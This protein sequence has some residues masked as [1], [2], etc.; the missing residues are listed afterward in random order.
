MSVDPDA[1]LAEPALDGLDDAATARTSRAPRRLGLALAEGAGRRPGGRHLA[2][3]RVE[4]LEAA[5]T[6]SPARPTVLRRTCGTTSA[7]RRASGTAWPRPLR[8]AIVGFALA[9]VI[10]TSSASRSSQWRVL[11]LGVGSLITGLQTMPSIA[12]FPLAILLFGL[13]E[14]AIIF[15][16]VLGAAPSIAAGVIT[17]IDEVRRRCCGRATC[18]VRGASTATATSSL[19]AAMPAYLAGLKQ[20]WAFSWRSLMAGELLVP[21]GGARLARQ[22]RS[23]YSR[24]RERRTWLLALMIVI[25]VIGMRDR[26]RSSASSPADAP[27]AR[28]DRD[29][30]DLTQPTRARESK[31]R[32]LRTG[33]QPSSRTPARPLFSRF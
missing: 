19:P 22:S 28:P 14:K 25:F 24:D 13:T 26:R 27:E 20:G 15:V 10:G 16:V 9:V 1:D 21:I 32:R 17:G 5:T 3:R 12:W 4:R 11:R 2:A 31:H 23:T 33:E 7:P 8:R 30:D 18:S 6:S 29:G